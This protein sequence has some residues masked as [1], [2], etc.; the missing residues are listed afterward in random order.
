V[1]STL[2]VSGELCSSQLLIA[3]AVPMLLAPAS[4]SWSSTVQKHSEPN[5]CCSGS[6]HG[7]ETHGSSRFMSARGS[8]AIRKP[9]HRV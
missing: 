1:A 4:L 5:A 6:D 2:D 7:R 8:H 3:R 9:R